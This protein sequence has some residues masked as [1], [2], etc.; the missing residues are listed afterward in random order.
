MLCIILSFVSSNKSEKIKSNNLHKIIKN[1][2]FLK[3]NFRIIYRIIQ[4]K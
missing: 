4:N 3:L 2:T 1:K